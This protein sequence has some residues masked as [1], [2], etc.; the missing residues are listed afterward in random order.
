MPWHVSSSGL[1]L[2]TYAEDWI[3]LERPSAAWLEW[4]VVLGMAITPGEIQRR[5][6]VVWALPS[7]VLSTG[8]T[9]VN[10]LD[11][12]WIRRG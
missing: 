8:V 6:D 7:L 2:M 1:P 9:G 5:V 4:I 12:A 10:G 3:G 11:M